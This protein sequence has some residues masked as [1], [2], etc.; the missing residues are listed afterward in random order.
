MTLAVV[1]RPAS[2]LGRSW[3][4]LGGGSRRP[5]MGGHSSEGEDDE[6]E[7]GYDTR[8]Y[9]SHMSD[10]ELA[11]D[12][13]AEAQRQRRARQQQLQEE[14]LSLVQYEE[15]RPAVRSQLQPIPA[16]APGA[17]G[18]GAAPAPPP[19]LRRLVLGSTAAAGGAT[20][21]ELAQ[22]R[23]SAGGTLSPVPESPALSSSSLM[24]A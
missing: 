15:A 5:G 6:G 9:T 11:D 10:A 16:P 7:D 19:P 4:R 13:A 12:A 24:S 18:P 22:F 1:L 20:S 3:R 8:L 2:R 14:G 17:A 21:L 23:G